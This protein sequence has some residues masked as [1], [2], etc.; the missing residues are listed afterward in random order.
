MPAGSSVIVETAGGGGW[1]NPL[2]RDPAQVRND[3]ID[4]LLSVDAARD[5][6]GVVLRHEGTVDDAA[7]AALRAQRR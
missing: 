3:V 2:E 1:G 4:G 5:D 6:Y 7:T